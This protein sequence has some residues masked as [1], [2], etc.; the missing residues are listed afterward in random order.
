[1]VKEHVLFLRACL[2]ADASPPCFTG[3][4][5][6]KKE[7]KELNLLDL[8]ME[9]RLCNFGKTQTTI[10][11]SRSLRLKELKNPYSEFS[12]VFY[13][14]DLKES[15]GNLQM[16][17]NMYILIPNSNKMTK[18]L[19]AMYSPKMEETMSAFKPS[20]AF[21]PVKFLPSSSEFL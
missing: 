2:T 16:L 14:D 17:F 3:K 12:S 10:S 21:A 5:E 1:M 8:S 20:L 9:T 15:L 11:N 13:M 7:T 19:N 6:K 18:T 4:S